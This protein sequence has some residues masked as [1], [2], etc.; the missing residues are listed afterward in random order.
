MFLEHGNSFPSYLCSMCLYAWCLNCCENLW[1]SRF[2]VTNSSRFN[3][4][5][6]VCQ[7][8]R[9]MDPTV[10]VLVIDCYFSHCEQVFGRDIFKGSHRQPWLLLSNNHNFWN[11]INISWVEKKSSDYFLW[12]VIKYLS[13]MKF[14]VSKRQKQNWIIAQRRWKRCIVCFKVWTV[15]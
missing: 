5:H 13:K 9:R 10:C 3:V 15:D 12:S 11:S 7:L 2:L 1:F 6:N 8:I 14:A 4:K